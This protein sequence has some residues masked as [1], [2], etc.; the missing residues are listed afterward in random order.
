MAF[1]LVNVQ[2]QQNPRGTNIL[3]QDSNTTS[4]FHAAMAAA[5]SLGTFMS[6]VEA[7]GRPIDVVIPL[8]TAPATD[9]APKAAYRVDFRPGSGPNGSTPAPLIV[10]A[11]PQTSGAV[12][13]AASILA[14]RAAEAQTSASAVQV[15]QIGLVEIDAT[16][17]A[18]TFATALTKIQ[19]RSLFTLAEL[20]A[21]DNYQ[22]DANLTADQKATIT[23]ILANF[24][25]ALD[26]S[27]TDP[28]TI[29]GVGYLATAQPSGPG[30]LTAAR[31]QQILAGQPA[32]A[33]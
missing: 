5:A 33:Q 19:F 28:L 27:L 25:A 20:V 12:T 8:A 31:A 13:T 9:D 26:I 11:W 24:A 6:A 18:S 30:L 21:I 10:L 16:G 22:T 15:S 29:Q 17:G 3:A 14:A 23:T 7:G 4:A 32:P 1:S 2:T